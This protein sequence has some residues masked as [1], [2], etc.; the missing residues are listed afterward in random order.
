MQINDLF[1]GR[2]IN[3]AGVPELAKKITCQSGL[4]LS[5]QASGIHYS[6]PRSNYGPYTEVEVGKTTQV[7][8]ELLPYAENANTPTETVYGYVPIEVVQQVIENHGGIG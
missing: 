5:V 6:T 2:K 8:D 7:V 4:E 3:S 1:E